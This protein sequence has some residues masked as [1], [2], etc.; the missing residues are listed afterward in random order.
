MLFSI[1]NAPKTLIESLKKDFYVY[2]AHEELTNMPINT[3]S[4]I[5]AIGKY[6]SR[7][8]V[9]FVG[10]LMDEKNKDFDKMRGYV[11]NN[12]K[13]FKEEI[14]KYIKERFSNA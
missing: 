7:Y 12:I 14:T 8:R 5:R 11:I 9:K 3:I 4:D 10:N 13:V 1:I 2:M 6:L